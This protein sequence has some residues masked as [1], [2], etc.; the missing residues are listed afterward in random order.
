MVK[1][2]SEQAAPFFSWCQDSMIKSYCQ[3]IIGDGYCDNSD[4]PN[5]SAIFISDFCY[6]GGQ[7]LNIE[8]LTKMIISK[9]NDLII[10]PNSD[11]W[12][13]PLVENGVNLQTSIRF[14]V[15]ISD[16]G[17]NLDFLEKI[18]L[19]VS[20]IDNAVLEQIGEKDYNEL[21]NCDWENAFVSNFKDY[22][23]FHEHGFGFVVKINDEIASG[24][25]TFGWYSDGVE[26]Q[27]ATNPKFRKMGLA[28]IVSAAFLLECE[29][30]KLK[31]HWDAGNIISLK[32]AQ[33]LGLELA[34]EY[35][36]FT[37][38]EE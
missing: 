21:R 8:N 19:E 13:E 24:A 34:G 4:N 2:S 17:L 3:G 15:K 14:H 23:D 26:L 32:T 37:F 7:P 29:K 6:L 38:K 18:R 12:F 10:I 25:S 5:W 30:R 36:S 22:N 16:K 11:S 9:G 33:K 35:I 28:T 1:V 27:I 20:K 31:I